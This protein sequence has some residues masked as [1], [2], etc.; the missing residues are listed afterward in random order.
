MAVKRKAGFLEA[1]ADACRR[2]GADDLPALV[3]IAGDEPFVKERL[4]DAVRAG[5]TESVEVFGQRPDESD[6]VAAR[7]LVE[8]WST[9]SLFARG[10][11]IIARNADKLMK[12]GGTAALQERLGSDRSA[13]VHRLVIT[14]DALD[15]RSKLAKSVKAA[16][17]LVQ[18]PPLRDAPPPWQDGPSSDTELNRWVIAEARHRGV[19]IDLKTADALTRRVGNEPANLARKI[20]QLRALCGDKLR[21]ADVAAHVRH[22][23]ARLL[24][25]YE[26]SLRGGDLAEALTLL[27]RMLAEGVYDHGMR[28]VSGAEAVD[29]VLRGLLTSFA[30]TLAV[31]EQL[32]PELHAA[33]RAKPWERSRP[34]AQALDAILGV[35]GPRVYVERDVRTTS[36]SGVR[37]AFGLALHGVRALRDGDGLS[38]HGLTVRMGRA[39]AGSAA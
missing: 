24:S 37:T 10:H 12:A 22:T 25:L 7:R 31:H 30:R 34:Q 26:T 11:T 21:T 1:H 33:L 19:S 36:H 27:D 4:I 20:D 13:P 16:G 38:L 2:L 9:P 8:L 3:V 39:L 23:S 17:G 35:G 28:L 5:A 6:A 32:S 29:T 15:G 14:I 18:L